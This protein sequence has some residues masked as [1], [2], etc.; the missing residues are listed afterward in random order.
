MLRA[1]LRQLVLLPA[2]VASA[3]LFLLMVMTFTDVMLRSVFNAPLQWG[4]DMTRLLM[5]IIVFSVMPTLSGQGGQIAVDLADPLF[6]RYRLE[7]W[8]DVAVNLF[9]GAILTWPALRVWDLAERA[10]SYGDV[11]EYL[12][13]PLH[14]IGW[15]IA[16]MTGLTALVLILRGLIGAFA[17][18]Y[19]ESLRA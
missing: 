6:T 11:M 10:R 7:R 12:G 4:A 5:A 19:L 18:H 15:F 9:C 17:P 13:L 14:Y 16:V 8:R 2:L 3:A 1:V